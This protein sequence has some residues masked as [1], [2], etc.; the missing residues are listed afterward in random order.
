MQHECGKR[1]VELTCGMYTGRQADSICVYVCVYVCENIYARSRVC[2]HRLVACQNVLMMMI[3]LS[4]LQHSSAI[5]CGAWW[6]V[7]DRKIKTRFPVTALLDRAQLNFK[8]SHMCRIGNET[9]MSPGM[10]SKKGWF[11]LLRRKRQTHAHTHI[12]HMYV[13]LVKIKSFIALKLLYRFYFIA[14]Q[15]CLDYPCCFVAARCLV[16]S[17]ALQSLLQ[18]LFLLL[19]LLYL[20]ATIYLFF[21]SFPFF[22]FTVSQYAWASGM[23]RAA[24]HIAISRYLPA[25]AALLLHAHSPACCTTCCI[26]RAQVISVGFLFSFYICRSC[27]C[28]VVADISR[29][30]NHLRHNFSANV[31][32]NGLVDFFNSCSEAKV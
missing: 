1:G 7:N 6:E 15:F 12:T 31:S 18:R 32:F 10:S 27:F 26:S 30:E 25:A 4:R 23:W 9:K 8:M 22:M 2:V 5:A 20:L 16:D 29:A 13:K 11:C 21:I 24:C 17:L 28:H 3:A 14:A 19:A